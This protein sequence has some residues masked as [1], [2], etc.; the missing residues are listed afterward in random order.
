VIPYLRLIT[1][2]GSLDICPNETLI[3]TASPNFSEYN[4]Y[5]NGELLSRGTDTLHVT[6]DGDYTVSA[7][8]CDVLV[9]NEQVLKVN[10]KV[11]TEPLTLELETLPT[12]FLLHAKPSGVYDNF[13]W[14]FENIILTETQTDTI[15]PYLLGE[16]KVETNVNGCILKSNSVLVS[17]PQGKLKVIGQNPG[18]EGDSV[19]VELPSGY[20]AYHWYIEGQGGY[21]NHE[22]NQVFKKKTIVSGAL[23]RGKLTGSFS[24]MDTITFLP[25]PPKPT[26]SLISSGLQSSSAINNQWFNNGKIIPGESQE[27]LQ[28][29]IG[30][31]YFVRVIKNGCYTDS[32]PVVITGIEPSTKTAIYPNPSTGVFWLNIPQGLQNVQ[33][34]IFDLKGNSVYTKLFEN[35]SNLKQGVYTKLSAGLYLV[36]LQTGDWKQKFK[37]LISP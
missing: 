31:N 27:I 34:E 22:S 20:T 8:R 28:N 14:H 37:L 30:G 33:L 2:S 9:S 35:G 32:D 26:V 24:S 29:P 5:R 18:C 11:T 7:K 16:Y 6:N 13:K 15:T 21:I 17:I 36:R 12:N 3:L 25:K 10:R 1:P 4:W 23:M 19:S